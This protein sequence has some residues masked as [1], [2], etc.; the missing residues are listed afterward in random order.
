MKSLE[1]LFIGTVQA[2]ESSAPAA[3]QP[4]QGNIFGMLLPMAVVFGIFYLLLIRPQAK[5][6]KQHQELLKGIKKGDEVVT[7]AGIHGKIS[8]IADTVVTLEIAD[9]VRVKID[10][11]QIASIKAAS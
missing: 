4:A 2:Q 9:N 5:Q 6:R 10:R 7:S 1:N 8:G 3:S 11:Q